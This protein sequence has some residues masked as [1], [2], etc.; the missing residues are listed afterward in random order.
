[1]ELYSE[2]LVFN[3][4]SVMNETVLSS[5]SRELGY[6]VGVGEDFVTILNQENPYR[7]PKSRVIA[8]NEITC[9]SVQ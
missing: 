3:W 4:D 5:N 1:M 7:I 9:N 8:F 6:I 2:G